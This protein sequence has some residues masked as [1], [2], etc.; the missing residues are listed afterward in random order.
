VACLWLAILS[1]PFI[2]AKSIV[3]DFGVRILPEALEN[4]MVLAAVFG[5]FS[6]VLLVAWSI[7][8][9]PAI[10][11]SVAGAALAAVAWVGAV[12]V[13]AVVVLWVAAIGAFSVPLIL[14]RK[15][16]GPN[17]WDWSMARDD[18]ARPWHARLWFWW[19]LF[20]A[21]LIGIYVRF[22]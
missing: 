5:E 7:E 19:S 9:P 3:T 14:K 8:W 11:W 10:R 15:M 18:T 20:A 21:I 4:P 16:P 6:L 2:L 12:S 1:I 17:L 13:P 22:W